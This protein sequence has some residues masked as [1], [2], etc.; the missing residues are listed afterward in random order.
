[1]KCL[2]ASIEDCKRLNIPTVV[3]HLSYS[4]SPPPNDVGLG[5]TKQIVEMAE[6]SNVNVAFENTG[7]NA[8]IHHIFNNIKSERLGFCFDSG[9]QN[10][11]K[12]NIDCLKEFG[13]RLMAMHLNDNDGNNDA[14]LLP[15]EGTVDWDKITQQLKYIQYKGAIAF[16]VD[17]NKYDYTPEEFLKKRITEQ[18]NL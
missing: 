7:A 5:R 18:K 9:H 15:F 12:T 13:N 4:E 14:H 17:S 8:H 3:A 10:L 11:V 16:E 2:L 6:Q 1:M